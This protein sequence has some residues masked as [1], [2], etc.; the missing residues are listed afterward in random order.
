LFLLADKVLKPESVYEQA[1]MPDQI[2]GTVEKPAAAM[3]D[4]AYTP[5]EVEAWIQALEIKMNISSAMKHRP[6][7]IVY[8]DAYGLKVE[9]EVPAGSKRTMG[10]GFD[11]DS[12]QDFLRLIA[13]PGIKKAEYGVAELKRDE[14]KY[15]VIL[16]LLDDIPDDQI[17]RLGRVIKVLG[18]NVIIQ[19]IPFTAEELDR[20]STKLLARVRENVGNEE[21]HKM[22]DSVL[23]SQGINKHYI[24]VLDSLAAE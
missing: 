11:P 22:L 16:R 13:G 2:V 7:P 5:E 23:G 17:L 6:E 21:W 10:L 20:I 24:D 9:V 19:K 1:S 18:Y 3:E 14:V 15:P 12:H 4:K 8:K